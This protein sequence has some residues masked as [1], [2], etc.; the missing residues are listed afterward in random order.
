MPQRPQK[1]EVK[2]LW[3]KEEEEG[4]MSMVNQDKVGIG[5]VGDPILRIGK[6]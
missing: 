1:E 4:G 5:V 2:E 3:K 6:V